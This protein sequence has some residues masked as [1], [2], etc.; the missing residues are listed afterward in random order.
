MSLYLKNWLGYDK[1]T[2]KLHFLQFFCQN[3]IWQF[4]WHL[5]SIFKMAAFEKAKHRGVIELFYIKN[6]SE[7][8]DQTYHHFKKYKFNGRPIYTKRSLYELMKKLHERGSLNR[9][10][11]SGRTRVF[12]N[13]D[14]MKLKKVVNHK[15]GC[16]QRKLATKFKVCQ[17]TIENWLKRLGVQYREGK[18]VSKQTLAQKKRQHEWLDLFVRDFLGGRDIVMDDES[19]FTTSDA[20]MPGNKGFYSDNP[21]QTP[22]EIKFNQVGKFDPDKVMIW[23]AFSRRWITQIALP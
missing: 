11:G 7:K 13:R 18:K 12:S 19:W 4:F 2:Q 5:S 17:R 8:K 9:S 10:I 1:K 3:V 14:G 6:T 21:Y 22:A 20:G 23:V 16:S 15:F